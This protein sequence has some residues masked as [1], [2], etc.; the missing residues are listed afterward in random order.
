MDKVSFSVD[1]E[2]EIGLRSWANGFTRGSGFE[3]RGVRAR[4]SGRLRSAT[5]PPRAD[6]HCCDKSVMRPTLPTLH[7]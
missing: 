2:T 3:C 7:L 1:L 5:H 6:S 4:I